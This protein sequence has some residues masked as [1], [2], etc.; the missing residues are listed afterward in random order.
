[1][2]ITKGTNCVVIGL[3]A[4]GLAAVR[5]L[6]GLGLHVSVSD[7]RA[8]NQ[9]DMP[10]LE[11]LR[12]LGVA[13]ETGGHTYDFIRNAQLIVPSPG[14]PL[15]LPV[16]VRARGEGKAVAGELAIAAGRIHRPVIGVTG[17]NGKTTVTSLLGHLLQAD[18][19]RVFIGGN[20]GTPVLDFLSDSQNV[21]A[22]VLE[23]SSF[24][25]RQARPCERSGLACVCPSAVP[26]S[27][28]WS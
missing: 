6:Y 26:D 7:S 3:G 10:S 8:E 1:M 18:N 4:S 14:V 23:L 13:V 20:I 9:M 11:E 15:D 27:G 5:F 24:Q 28:G 2:Q 19:Q 25:T 21:D 12:E 17:S 22:L 16:I